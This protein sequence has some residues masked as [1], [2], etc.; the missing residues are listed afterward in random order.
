MRNRIRQLMTLAAKAACKSDMRQ[1]KTGAIIAS[2]GRIESVGYNSNGTH[3]I[4][5]RL[6]YHGARIHAELRAIVRCKN[7]PEGLDIYV[8]RILA[9]GVSCAKPCPLCFALI[10]ESGIRRIYYTD[11]NGEIKRESC[12][13]AK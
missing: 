4:A 9:N 3:P 6:G 1:F 5:A 2:R 8:V 12:N 7:R 13:N 11:W 10:V